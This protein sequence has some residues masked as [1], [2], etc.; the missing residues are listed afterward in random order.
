MLDDNGFFGPYQ[1]PLWGLWLALGLLGV[2]L[3]VGWYVFVVRFSAR[4]LPP[5]ERSARR[6]ARVDLPSVREKYLD[7]ID[8]VDRASA[9]GRLDD[10]AVHARLSLLLRFFVHE[11][12][13]VETHVMTLSDLREADLPSPLTGAVEQNYPPAFRRAHPGDP[14][15]AVSTA[16]EVVRSWA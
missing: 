6:A 8:E 12:E 1:Y 2:A 10:R 3:V 9:D 5:A 16:R 11:T 13:G 4:R 7:L 15:G 14:A